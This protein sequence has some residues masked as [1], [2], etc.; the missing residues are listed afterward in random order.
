VSE[1]EKPQID[2]P[3]ALLNRRDVSAQRLETVHAAVAAN[4]LNR[5]HP[6]V[7]VYATGS[8][9]RGEACVHSDLD[10]FCVDVAED[11][12]QRIGRLDSIKLFS[13]LIRVNE[14]GGFPA[15]SGD[16]RFLD[17]HLMDDLLG[18]LGTRHD[19]YR[20]LFTARMLLLLESQVLVGAPAYEKAVKR[21]IDLYWDDCQDEQ[22]FRPTFLV[23]DLVR[24]WK[25]LCLAHEV[26]R[27][28]SHERT[29]EDKRRRR[30]AVL[31]LQFNR[32]WMVFNGLAHL[33]SGF[34]GTQGV[35]RLHME[36]L[37]SYSPLERVLE[38]GEHDP[39]LVTHIQ[40]LLNEYAWFLEQTDHAKTEIEEFF[41]SDP[42]YD[43]GRHRGEVFCACMAQLVDH[44]AK[45][46]PIHRHLLI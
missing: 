27:S 25:T 12:A 43:E 16:G 4:N 46:T 13:S 18:L 45:T 14:A 33:L 17:I 39:S 11:P 32:V 30:V 6:S 31:K 15:F 40:T 26:D 20:N 3:L 22:T 42:N 10:I 1:S 9:G 2:V 44:I 23:N 38:M 35:P 19:D 5:D 29:E 8:L 41:A 7:V 34:G 28:P 36:K 37:V 24:Y 21:V